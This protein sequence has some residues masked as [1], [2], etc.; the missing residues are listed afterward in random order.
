MYI[1]D[2][3]A[4]SGFREYCTTKAAWD[5]RRMDLAKRAGDRCDHCR[6]H[7]PFP[8]GDAAHI[9]A[10]GAGGDDSLDNLWWLCRSSHVKKHNP[11]AVP[12]RQR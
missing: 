12:P 1:P 9:K 2:P 7:A 4:P 6:C 3:L 10:T 11:K 5:R 8:N